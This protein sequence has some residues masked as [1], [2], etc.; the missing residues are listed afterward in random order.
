VLL[1]NA[2][3]C[4][5]QIVSVSK[6]KFNGGFYLFAVLAD[7]WSERE[8]SGFFSFEFL[9]SKSVSLDEM[10]LLVGQMAEQGLMFDRISVSVLA[11]KE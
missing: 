3:V 9:C 2:P 5:I 8:Y 4:K 11:L 7:F 1:F 6:I 10:S